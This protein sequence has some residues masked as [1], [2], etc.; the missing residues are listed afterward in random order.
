MSRCAW[1]LRVNVDVDV[2]T[3]DRPPTHAVESPTHTSGA[4]SKGVVECREMK[5]C[6]E[7]GVCLGVIGFASEPEERAVHQDDGEEDR[8]ILE[9]FFTYVLCGRDMNKDTSE[10]RDDKGITTHFRDE[11]RRISKYTPNRRI[12][13]RKRVVRG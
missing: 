11:R 10:R 7:P 6:D 12:H 5:R 1:S 3:V 13:R 9:D 2:S 4:P 8:L